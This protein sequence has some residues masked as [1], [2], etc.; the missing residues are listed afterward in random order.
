MGSHRL[1]LD[2]HIGLI[3]LLR[4]LEGGIKENILETSHHSWMLTVSEFLI[5]LQPSILLLMEK[6]PCEI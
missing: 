5:L 2:E 6:E 3:S 4:E 1:V